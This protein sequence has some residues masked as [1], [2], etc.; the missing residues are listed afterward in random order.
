MKNLSR[1]DAELFAKVAELI[2]SDGDTKYVF[3][4]NKLIE[5]YGVFYKD[6][7]V[8]DECG[9]INSSGTLSINHIVSKEK[10]FNI[11]TKNRIAFCT[12]KKD[13]DKKISIEIYTLT[14]AGREL[15]KI[16]KAKSNND[17]FIEALQG[18]E[19]KN[20]GTILFSVHE[21]NGIEKESINYK[22]EPIQIIES[23]I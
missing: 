17:F 22:I 9:L 8:L 10:S 21:V 23:M 16:I 14:S 11:Y 7:M 12:G 18:I 20:K 19:S 6:I 2:V 4:M 1:K 15:Y 5:K 13:E 3:S